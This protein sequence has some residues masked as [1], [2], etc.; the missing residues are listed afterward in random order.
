M[1]S[2]V[3]CVVGWCN[4]I[5]TAPNYLLSTIYNPRSQLF[6]IDWKL[7][8]PLLVKWLP[9]GLELSRVTQ[10][11]ARPLP[12]LS[13]QMVQQLPPR[14]NNMSTSTSTSIIL[15]WVSTVLPRLQSPG[16]HLYLLLQPG[17]CYD[18]GPGASTHTC[19]PRGLERGHVASW[20]AT[21]RDTF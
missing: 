19:Q 9:W 5:R 6:R 21:S 10:T 12:A 20:A 8:C 18:S 15:V 11:F 17:R 2:R 16:W 14:V 13:R 4:N 1:I 7:I 3:L